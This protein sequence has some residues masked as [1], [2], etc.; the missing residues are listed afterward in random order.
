MRVNLAAA[1][2]EAKNIT[3][4][5]VARPVKPGLRLPF[6]G[7]VT[8]NKPRTGLWLCRC[9]GINFYI[10]LC[11][12]TISGDFVIPAWTCKNVQKPDQAFFEQESVTR[13]VFMSARSTSLASVK[14][15]VQNPRTSDMD[16]V[17]NVD[18]DVKVC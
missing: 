8:R 4:V 9:F 15:H 3:A 16:V 10:A 5:V 7:P 12:D 14:L 11:G 1:S 6:V 2:K 13:T 17:E 18:D